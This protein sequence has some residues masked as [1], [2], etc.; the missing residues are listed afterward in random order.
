MCV[1]NTPQL[2]CCALRERQPLCG[3]LSVTV[4]AGHHSSSSPQ[5]SSRQPST[6]RASRRFMGA[7]YSM[8]PPPSPQ[9]V[10]ATRSVLCRGCWFLSHVDRSALYRS[11][12]HRLGFAWV[13]FVQAEPVVYTHFQTCSCVIYSF[14]APICLRNI[15]E[16]NPGWFH[17]LRLP[18]NK[19]TPSP[20]SPG[21]LYGTR[22]LSSAVLLPSALLGFTTS[23][24]L[25]RGH[26]D[27]SAC[28]DR[29]VWPLQGLG[30]STFTFVL[31]SCLL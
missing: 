31:L 24:A 12:V 9:F 6:F 26:R 18:A 3:F 7:F 21:D 19:S 17:L 29:A 16:G 22:F 8:P 5:R 13:F 10:C 15:K 27:R 4:P 14:V 30:V 23:S 11:A 2:W 1:F 20:S 28:S 25:D